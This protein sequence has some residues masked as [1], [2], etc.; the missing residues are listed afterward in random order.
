MRVFTLSAVNL[1]EKLIDHAVRLRVIDDE[2]QVKANGGLNPEVREAI[3]KHKSALMQLVQAGNHKW[4]P[5]AEWEFRRNGNR[6]SGKRL[7]A[8]GEKSWTIKPH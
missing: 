3:K 2:L 6:M 4:R 8:P 5:V 7:D 1:L